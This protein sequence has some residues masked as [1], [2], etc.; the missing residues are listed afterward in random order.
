MCPCILKYV[1]VHCYANG[2]ISFQCSLQYLVNVY[3]K[4]VSI[5]NIYIQYRENICELSELFFERWGEE[6]FCF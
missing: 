2:D 6:I 4:I 3:Q 5:Y 1:S